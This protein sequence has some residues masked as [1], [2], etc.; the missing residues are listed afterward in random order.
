M[1]T[2]YRSAEDIAEQLHTAA[3]AVKRLFDSTTTTPAVER[4]QEARRQVWLARQLDH[5]TPAQIAAASGV[6]Q[7]LVARL[8]DDPDAHAAALVAARHDAER[9]ERQVIEDIRQSALARW[10]KATDS[11]QQP[12]PRGTKAAICSALGISAPTLDEWIASLD[13]EDGE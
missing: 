9:Y 10:R 6:P 5:T 12:P 2:T 3:Q 8:V 1:T 11:G 7:L 13:A 4:E